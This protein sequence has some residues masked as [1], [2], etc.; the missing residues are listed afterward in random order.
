MAFTTVQDEGTVAALVSRI[1]GVDE[2]SA[3]ARRAAKALVEANPEL[4]DLRSLAPGTMIEVPEVKGAEPVEALWPSA[5]VAAAVVL[6]GLRAGL[7]LLDTGLRA[8]AE[9]AESDARERLK[10]L[11]SAEVKRLARE[12]PQVAV[13]LGLA[14]SDAEADVAAARALRGEYR[15][16]LPELRQNL[17]VLLE[18][19]KDQDLPRRR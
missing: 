10:A 3:V 4:K 8:V 19:L 17:N 9:E 1:F 15:R 2:R 5:D 6:G 18:L 12:E 7:D 16:A 11:R 13:A 14:A